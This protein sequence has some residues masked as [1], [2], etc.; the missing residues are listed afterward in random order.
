MLRAKGIVRAR[1]GN[2]TV[3]TTG[4]GRPR[5]G[6]VVGALLAL[7]CASAGLP[8]D[9]IGYSWALPLNCPLHQKPTHASSTVVPVGPVAPVPAVGVATTA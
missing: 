2:R 6:L 7:A 5:A 1:P 3:R 4:A 8:G 9:D